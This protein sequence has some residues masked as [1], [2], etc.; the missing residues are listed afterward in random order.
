MSSI[1]PNSS[2]QKAAALLQE[3]SIF[4]KGLTVDLDDETKRKLAQCGMENAFEDWT[5]TWKPDQLNQQ[6]Q[7]QQQN[8]RPPATQPDA[9]HMMSSHHHHSPSQ[10]NHD[11]DDDAYNVSTAVPDYLKVASGRA[12]A[13]RSSA[14][15][16]GKYSKRRSSS[17]NY[18]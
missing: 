10:P 13:L 11:D 6:Q 16:R 4:M 9:S 7:Q 12:T 8:T 2:Q 17:C 3:Q 14:L 5:K 18:R 15:Q 1:I